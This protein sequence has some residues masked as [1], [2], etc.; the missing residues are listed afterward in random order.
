MKEEANLNSS[1]GAFWGTG[2]RRWLSSVNLI[3]VPAIVWTQHIR[4]L[5]RPV[6]LMY[7]AML[8]GG[9][10]QQSLKGDLSPL[11][12]QET[13]QPTGNVF[14]LFIPSLVLLN[15]K[16]AILEADKEKKGLFR[17]RTFAGF[18]RTYSHAIILA[19]C[20]VRMGLST[21]TSSLSFNFCILV[22]ERR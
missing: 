3:V 8:K 1:T 18:W 16:R 19:G 9:T 2:G 15:Y 17:F 22:I 6:W 12:P 20:E 13:W 4:L 14:I 11:L 5:I 7:W 10:L 21:C